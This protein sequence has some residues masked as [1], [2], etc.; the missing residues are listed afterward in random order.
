MAF[1][2]HPLWW[3]LLAG[4][5][6]AVIPAMAVKRKRFLNNAATA[7]QHNQERIQAAQPLDL[8]ELEDL[9]LTVLVEEKAE[10][11]FLGDAGVSYLFSS[12]RGSL[13]YDVGF[14]PERP[15]LAHNAVR[16]GFQLGQ[17][18]ALAISHLHPDHMGGMKAVSAGKVAIPDTLGQ[19]EGQPCYLPDKAEA[20]GFAQ[21]V[22]DAPALLSAGL[23]TTGP[24]ARS[25][26]FMGLTKEQ[27]IV[28]HIRDKGLVVFTGCGHP[29]AEVILE[30]ARRLSDQPLYAFGGGLHFPVTS[31]RGN[32][33]GISFQQLIGTGKPPWQRIN[34]QDLG[35][36]IL[37]INRAAPEK[38]FLSAHDTCDH[39][40]ERLQNELAAETTVLKAGG[41][42]SI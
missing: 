35:N 28:G 15:A 2:I 12:D 34:D 14:G 7:D 19:P 40:I 1:R 3:P 38:V 27:A 17:A 21:Q 33:L 13:L 10:D 37:A 9:T 31:G 5:S 29:T 42:Y 4:A 41:T 39:A 6:P 24:L 20:P 26:F 25:L 18:D 30:M 16:L 36:T 32:R 8:P 11:G 23:G 22:M